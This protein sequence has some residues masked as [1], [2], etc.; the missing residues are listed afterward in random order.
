MKLSKR[1]DFYAAC[2]VLCF[3]L[4]PPGNAQTPQ[5]ARVV[6]AV[7]NDK[8][9]ALG[10]HLHPQ[11]RAANDRGSLPDLQPVTRMHLLLKRSAAQETELEQL[12]SEQQD[13]KSPRYHAWLTPQQFGERFGPADADVRAVR[14]WLA[15]Q[16]FTELK[17]ANGR[18]LVEFNG[19]AQ[20]IRNAFH[21]EMH[22]LS[23]NGREHFANM[24]EPKI[25]SALVPVVAGIAGLHNFH[26]KPQLKRFG[27]FRRD[28]KT[29]EITP[30][31]TFSDVNGTFYG[32]GPAD[33]AKIYNVPSAYDGTGVSI[34]VVAQ[35]NINLQDVA[36]FRAIFG[37]PANPPTVI[38]NG[39]DPG[40]V[41]GDQG[42]SDLDVE[43]A[44][45]V[46]PKAA[47]K[48]V[49]TQSSM[50]D[51]VSGVDGS[52]LYI[53]DNN[54]AP[55]LTESY[56]LCESALGTGGNQFYK[57]L[58]QQAAAEGITVAVSAGDNGSA[59]CD[60]PNSASSASSGIAVS[61][62]AS[63]PFN[64]AMGGTDFDQAGNQSTYWNGS[65]GTGQLS[66]KGYIPEIVWNDSCGS[67]GL[68]GCNSATSGSDSLNIVA[69]S[70]AP[71]SLYSKPAYQA[72]GITGM[73]GDGKR[74]LPDVSLF[75]ADGGN[76]SFYIVCESDADIAGDTGCNLTAFSTTP[77]FHDFQAVGGTS[78]AA[79]AFAGIMALVNQKTG[80]RHGNANITLYAL[81]KSETY[82]SCNSS[83]GTSGSASNTTCVFNDITKGTN[84]VPCAGG[85]TNCSKTTSGGFGVLASGAS[86]AYAAGLGYDLATGLGSINVANLVNKWSTPTLISTSVTLG[87]SPSTIS[88]TVGSTFTLSGT[89]SKSSGTATPSGTVVFQNSASGA[90]LDSTTLASN[91]T[92]SV[93]TAFLP[94]GSY[95]MKAHYGGDPTFAPSDSATLAVNLAKQNST[96]TVSFVTFNGNSSVVSTS[97][98]TVAYGSSYILRVDVLGSSSGSC[99]DSGGSV[100]QICPTGTVNLKDNGSALND[101][102]SA[103]NPAATSVAALNDRGFAE[104]QPPIQLNVGTHAITASYTANAASSYN[105]NAASNSLSVTVTQAPTTTTVVSSASGIA[106]GASVT[107]TATVNSD[108]NSAA[109]P[110]G[111][112]QFLSGGVNLGAAATCTPAAATS[113]AGASCKATLTTTL[114]LVPPGFLV[115]APQNGPRP[116]GTWVPAVLLILL[117]LAAARFPRRKPYAYA[118]A[119]FFFLG[120]VLLGAA[121]C[122][123]GGGGGGNRGTRTITA[124]YSGDS[125]YAG[126]TSTAITITVQ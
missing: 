3:G 112:V 22:R 110:S 14:D 38:L 61:G 20:Q 79:P 113:S 75:S 82:S 56:G 89:V 2:A 100:V 67:S 96:V 63:T 47:V 70:G 32:I 62:L 11:A 51:G 30:L 6:E 28:M 31:F 107:L 15:S 37:L 26:P 97:P 57:L 98:Q 124:T 34:A 24:Q 92:Y 4:L 44:G 35:S 108:S 73:P 43:W 116:I 80:Q 58:W 76:G 39:P 33:F 122:G 87:S 106:S 86:A 27:K 88:G 1:A 7:E 99:T 16:G 42:E 9:V 13:P 55:I 77:P 94:A 123:G 50:T 40:L 125:N 36:D 71:S 52:A 54:V 95:A 103:A 74:D 91:A 17:L 59:G 83:G 115:P 118:G 120:V 85:N 8:V 60:D 101:F 18:T 10:G 46:A 12:L 105:S 68:N 72:A 66:A 19:T 93:S 29:G 119:L 109:G 21:T 69:G 84:A 78:V 117:A 45:A 104:D 53:V 111:T 5:Q 126:S 48:L 25:P 49:V 102:P 114:A 81:A 121:G 90:P 41:S 23:V 64:V 65:N